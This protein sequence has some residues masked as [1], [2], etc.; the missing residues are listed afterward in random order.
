MR[1][2]TAKFC[3]I[4][5]SLLGAFEATACGVVLGGVSVKSTT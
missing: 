5:C 3:N 1:F 4:I 2:E